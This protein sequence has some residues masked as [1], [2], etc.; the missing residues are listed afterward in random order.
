MLYTI[1]QNMELIK[2]ICHN[3]ELDYQGQSLG[4]LISKVIEEII[5]TL[6]KSSHISAV[7]K[8]LLKAKKGRALTRLISKRIC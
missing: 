2:Q 7:F 3:M 6:P 4:T 5:Q 8:H 1:N